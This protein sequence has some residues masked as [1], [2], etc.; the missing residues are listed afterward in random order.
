MAIEAVDLDLDNTY[1]LPVEP[2]EEGE[3][4]GRTVQPK[5]EEALPVAITNID[6]ATNDEGEETAKPLSEKAIVV[7]KASEPTT[8]EEDKKPVKGL[9]I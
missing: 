2:A 3:L 5:K 9:R 7:T 4:N 1:A 6:E 8:G